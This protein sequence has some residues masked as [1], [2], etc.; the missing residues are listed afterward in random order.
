MAN[1]IISGTSNQRWR[2]LRSLQYK[3]YSWLR[4]IVPQTLNISDEPNCYTHTHWHTQI[5]LSGL[6]A[7]LKPA[8]RVTTFRQHTHALDALRIGV[9]VTRRAYTKIIHFRYLISCG[10]WDQLCE[11]YRRV[12]IT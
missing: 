5:G 7:W 11:I 4:R 8:K 10:K 9:D 12:F 6:T 3:V 2:P 1:M